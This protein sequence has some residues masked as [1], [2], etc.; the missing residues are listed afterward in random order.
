LVAHLYPSTAETVDVLGV[1]DPR[2]VL[3]EPLPKFFSVVAAADGLRLHSPRDEGSPHLVV[4]WGE[5]ANITRSTVGTRGGTI[6][7]LNITVVRA[8]RI[9]ELQ[10]VIGGPLLW[11]IYALG[12]RGVVGLIDEL[13]VL[14]ATSE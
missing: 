8:S 10:L 12:A 6:A 11:G 14:R 3:G 5:V 13:T 2:R 7:A 9:H 1:S 4:Q